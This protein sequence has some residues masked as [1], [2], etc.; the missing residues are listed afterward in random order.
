MKKIVWLLLLL[1]TIVIAQKNTES[2]TEKFVLALHAK[3]FNWMVEQKLD[4][5]KKVLDERLVY[6]HS[7]GWMQR[8]QDVIDDFK[9]GKLKYNSV[10]VDSA[11]ARVYQGA[12]IVVGKAL[13]NATLNG[14]TSD[15]SLLY[16]EIYVRKKE[17]W[18][19]VSRHANRLP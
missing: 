17:G 14:N 15:F 13:I 7:N 5:L 8:K 4:S 11:G 16:T 19:L 3:K 9:N 18:L 12:V 1:P 6:I 10:R 2:A